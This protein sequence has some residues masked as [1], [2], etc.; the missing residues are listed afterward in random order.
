MA[1]MIV[2]KL[3]L[4]ESRQKSAKKVKRNILYR[5]RNYFRELALNIVQYKYLY[6]LI[7]PCIIFY[8]IFWLIPMYGVQIAFKDLNPALGITRSPWVG[9]KYF[10]EFFMYY[11]IRRLFINTIGISLLKIVFGF[12]APIL[13]AL[14]INEVTHKGFKR[15]VQTISYLPHFISWVIISTMIY[16]LFSLDGIVNDMMVA[17]FGGERQVH[18]VNQN[19]FWPLIIISDIWKEVG[20][21]SIIYLAAIAGVDQELY[22]AARVDG[23]GRFRQI[24]NITLPG[25]TPTIMIMFILRVGSVMRAGFDQIYTLSNG[26]VSEV[27]DILEIYVVTTGLKTGQFGYASAVDLFTGL[28]G[29]TFMII[30][31]KLSRKYSETSLW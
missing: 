22:E 13:L 11:Q 25:I 15:I 5:V 23:A 24:M 3:P 7:L 19:I 20:F 9:L 31:N 1:D 10:R 2:S 6:L 27:T 30:A 16:R 18:M 26:A 28:I 14:M 4:S 29:M 17:I 12:G 8:A 21:A